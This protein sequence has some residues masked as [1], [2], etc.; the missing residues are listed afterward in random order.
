MS[1]ETKKTN[2]NT[3]ATNKNTEAQKNNTEAQRKQ[4]E[5]R[6]KKIQSIKEE[7]GLTEELGEADRRRAVIDAEYL[8]NVGKKSE[9]RKIVL[10]QLAAIKEQ[11]LSLT[12]AEAEHADLMD[13]RSDLNEQ[14]L[15]QLERLEKSADERTHAMEEQADQLKRLEAMHKKLGNVTGANQQTIDKFST[16]FEKMTKGFV[17]ADH[18]QSHVITKTVLLGKELMASDKPLQVL[19]EG[20]F[21]VFNVANLAAAGL[22]SIYEE[23]VAM[24][25]AFDQAAAQ[26]SK[27]TGLAREYSNVLEGTQRAG[28]QFSVGA[29]EAGEATAGLL[30]NFSDFH[31]TAPAVQ[32][33]LALNVGALTKFGVSADQSARVMQIFSKTMGMTGKESVEMTKKIGMMGTK[34]GITTGKMLKDYEASLKTLAVYGDKSIDVFTGIAAAAKAAGVE[35][36]T[37]LG[38]AEKFDTFSS[39]AETT[40]KLNAIMGSQLSTTEMLMKTEDERIKTLVGTVQATGQAFSSM[41]RFTQKAIAQAAGISDMAEANKIFGMSLSEYDNYEAQ[42]K[43]A[44]DTQKRFEDALK[45][46]QPFMEKLSVLAEQ[47]AGAFLPVLNALIVP[48]DW[49]ISGFAYLNEKSSGWFGTIIGGIA[50]LILLKKALGMISF[51]LTKKLGLMAKE[52]IASMFKQADTTKEIMMTKAQFKSEK[53]MLKLQKMKATSMAGGSAAMTKAIPV[54]LAFGAAVLMIGAGI[55]LAAFGLSYL[56]E[57]FAQ[58]DIDKI[59]VVTA[60]ILALGFGMYGLAAGLASLSNP[61]SQIGLLVFLGLAAGALAIGI[62]VEK[63]ANG[64][65]NF[66]GSLADLEKVSSVLEALTGA[67]DMAVNL[68]MNSNI[69]SVKELLEDVKKAD[70]KAELENIALIT[71]GTSSTLMTKNAVSQ[72]VTVAALADTIKNVFNPDI[73]IQI[74]GDAMDALIENGVYKTTMR[75]SNQ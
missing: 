64:M 31:K 38:L 69:Q 74:D 53:R 55:G 10:K 25:V 63:A 9:A 24:A 39:A 22:N 43:S 48:L 51:G 33:D 71:T 27:T 52:R 18:A 20:F 19:S 60:A 26:F 41:D 59:L 15:E 12:A 49:M 70:I 34:I 40:G 62:A 75:K 57:A 14:E 30:A 68:V 50:G 61:L 67:K 11:Q 28:S 3:E 21:N 46:M 36:S 56:V 6:K 45:S 65:A 23:T 2:E 5:E 44:N 4:S 32:K 7:L 58:M 37:L 66:I 54:M 47:F 16:A 13:R 29:K 35:T 1:D 8:M 17:R 73:T 42:M 72:L